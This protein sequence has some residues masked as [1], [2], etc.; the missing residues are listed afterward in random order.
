MRLRRVNTPELSQPGQ[1]TE[2]V[3]T[4]SSATDQ[5]RRRVAVGLNDEDLDHFE[6][7]ASHTVEELRCLDSV[8]AGGADALERSNMV[9]PGMIPIS[10]GNGRI[11]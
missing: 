7:V 9:E 10:W 6:S 11:S 5:G 2:T 8:S 4:H 1:S 3:A